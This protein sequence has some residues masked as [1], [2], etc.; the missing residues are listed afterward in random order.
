MLIRVNIAG[1]IMD[2]LFKAPIVILRSRDGKNTVLIW[3]AMLEASSIIAGLREI[4]FDRPMTHDLFKNFMEK[5]DIIV[6]SAEI[7]DMIDNKYYGKIHFKTERKNLS[8]DARPSDA[9]AMALRFKA[10]IYIDKK[11]FEKFKIIDLGSEIMDKSEQGKI[12]AEYLDKLSMDDFGKY[13]T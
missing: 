5:L 8:I 11:V 12:W 9:I 2:P 10:P 1:L 7:S 3:I 4:A 6:T 13:M